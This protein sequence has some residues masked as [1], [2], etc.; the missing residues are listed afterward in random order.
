LKDKRSIVNSTKERIRH[1]FNVSIAE[2][3]FQER[4]NYAEIGIAMVGS[5]NR[6]LEEVFSKII[7]CLNNDGRFEIVE[8]AKVI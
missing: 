8:V 3:D 2:V 7:E 4:H 5:D 6:Y 1:R